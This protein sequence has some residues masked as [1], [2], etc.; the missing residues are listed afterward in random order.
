MVFG[1]APPSKPGGAWEYEVLYS[2]G[3]VRN[4]GSDPR[5]VALASGMLYGTT[6][7]GGMHA[8]GTI[9]QLGFSHGAWK[10]TAVYNFDG[11]IGTAP[12]AGLLIHDGAAF[13]TCTSGG[14]SGS[15]TVFE[16]TK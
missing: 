7:G 9:F 2:F 12:E 11:G 15:G 4:D 14:D 8:V 13:G 10:E 5:G 16:I 3:S 1:L 6:L